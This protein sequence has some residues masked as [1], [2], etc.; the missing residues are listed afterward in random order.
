LTIHGLTNV[1][2]RF[3]AIITRESPILDGQRRHLQLDRFVEELLDP[4]R[5]VEERKLRMEVEVDE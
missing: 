4:A 2:C 5:T 3:G 1:D